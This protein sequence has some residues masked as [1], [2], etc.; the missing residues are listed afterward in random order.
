MPAFAGWA[1]VMEMLVLVDVKPAGPLH[2]TVYGPVPPAGVTVK[3]AVLPTQTDL[4]GGA[5]LHVG[6]GLTVR[7]TSQTLVHPKKSVTTTRKIPELAGCALFS[8]TFGPV[9]ENPPGPVQ[10][11]VYGAVP[12]VAVTLKLAE[13][14]AQTLATVEVASQVTLGRTRIRKP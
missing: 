3:V 11:K 8:V 7:F 2:T 10:A 12:F 9:A 13:P 1:F 4:T 5:M 14:P 6:C